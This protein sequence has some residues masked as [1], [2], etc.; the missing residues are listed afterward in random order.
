MAVYEVV[1][2]LSILLAGRMLV[3]RQVTRALL[4][5]AWAHAS[6]TSVRHMPLFMIVA[7]PFLALE[8]SQLLEAGANPNITVESSGNCFSIMGRIKAENSELEQELRKLLIS[9]GGKPE[10]D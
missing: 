2:F 6:L 3:R 4:V 1:L 8:V 5:L 9:H 10:K 7:V